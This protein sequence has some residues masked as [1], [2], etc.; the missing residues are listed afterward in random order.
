MPLDEYSDFDRNEAASYSEEHNGHTSARAIYESV[1]E[2]AIVLNEAELRMLATQLSTSLRV[3]EMVVLSDSGVRQ[4]LYRMYNERV[5][6]GMATSQLSEDFNMSVRGH[7]DAV[8]RHIDN[9]FMAAVRADSQGRNEE[10]T[11]YLQ[12]AKLRSN[13]M[14]SDRVVGLVESGSS[15]AKMEL[16]RIRQHQN[17]VFRSVLPLAAKIARKQSRGLVGTSMEFPDMLQ[18]SFLAALQVVSH[19]HPID[20]GKTLSSFMYTSIN[21]V[22]SRRKNELT[23]N[24]ALPRTLLDRF[25]YVNRAAK[26]LG[27]GKEAKE[28]FES[29]SEVERK[30]LCA[31]ASAL[32]PSGKTQYTLQELADLYRVTQ[33]EAS[34]DMVIEADT[35]GFTTTVG[36]NIADDTDLDRAIDM[37]YAGRRLMELMRPYLNQEEYL[38][39]ELRWGMGEVRSYQTTASQYA[40][41]TGR[42]MNKTSASTVEQRVFKRL[43]RA[44]ATDP[45]LREKFMQIWDSI[46]MLE[47]M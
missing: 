9:C 12:H 25:S 46:D 22:L 5:E 13:V 10:A 3:Y 23:R 14:F 17:A 29:L 45:G 44:A 18:E 30:L 2:L 6:S 39:L 28:D 38:L 32:L 4:E 35:D 1:G 34:L 20:E 15:D 11:G 40:E 33:I 47:A 36:D 37:K 19:Y 16:V 27:M 31:K 21:G 8:K 43:R 26:E 24:V 41:A 42:P 7:N